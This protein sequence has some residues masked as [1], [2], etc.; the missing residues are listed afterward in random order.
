MAPVCTRAERSR[1]TRTR[2]PRNDTRREEPE[3]EGE[4]AECPVCMTALGAGT[5]AF[6]CGHCVCSECDVKL[7]ERAFYSCPTCREP[8]AGMSTAQ[9]DAAAMERVQRDALSDQASHSPWPSMEVGVAH[10]GSVYNVVFLAD[11]SGDARPYDVLRTVVPGRR[12]LRGQTLGRVI[13][14]DDGQPVIDLT[15]DEDNAMEMETP[16]VPPRPSRRAQMA[17]PAPLAAMVAEMLQPTHL[18]EWL[19]RH[20]ALAAMATSGGARQ[21]RQAQQRL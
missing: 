17:L 9:V 4:E 11:E 6:P 20:D 7:R 21:R 8:R 14:R 5:F 15:G 13:H 2:L 1:R 19:R 10:N 3:N 16:P 18:P 12:T